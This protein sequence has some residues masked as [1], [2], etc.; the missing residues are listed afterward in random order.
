M[1]QILKSFGDSINGILDSPIVQVGIRA[2]ALYVVLL[3]LG[4]AFWAFRDASRRT[5][6]LIA[7]YA[8]GAL[9][10][11]ATPVFFPF[12]LILYAIVRPGETLVESWERRMTEEAAAEAV[13]LCAGCGRR[14]DPDWLACPTCGQRLHH[15]CAT[16]GR[17]MG[18]EWNLCAWC[19]TEV[20][21]DVVAFPSPAQAGA[22][23]RRRP[24]AVRSGAPMAIPAESALPLA[25]PRREAFAL[26]R[27]ADDRPA[28]IEATTHQGPADSDG[29]AAFASRPLPLD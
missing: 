9:V 13:P 14:T 24:R 19:G 12:A 8:A 28:G 29:V 25:S 3:W 26:G 10:V 11:L 4:S 6:N 2:I 15:R 21:P 22:G 16:C 20:A 5:R 1:D 18:L 27:A 23:V 17:L 7:P